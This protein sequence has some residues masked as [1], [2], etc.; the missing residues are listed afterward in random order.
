[1]KR[2]LRPALATEHIV[3]ADDARTDSVRRYAAPVLLLWVAILILALPSSPARASAVTVTIGAAAPA[4]AEG[5]EESLG[6]EAVVDDSVD[7]LA[8]IFD[9]PDYQRQLL[10]PGSGGQAFLLGLK[11]QSVR[12][13][14]L[15]AV[16][17]TAGEQALPDP[18]QGKDGGRLA[19]LA[20]EVTFDAG[21]ASWTI[22]PA[23]PMVG[24]ITLEALR[25]AKPDY[26]RL[27]GKYTP[28]AGA[29]K[30]IAAARE[31]KIV[32][33]FGNWCHLCKKAVPQLLKTVEAAKNPG[34]GLEFY[35]VTEDHLEPK[36]PIAKYSI[37]TTPVFVIIRGGKE[38]GRITEKPDV[39]V[40]KDLALILAAK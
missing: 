18:A 5:W 19:K 21:G 24:A 10:V 12:A 8:R 14:P 23:P 30:S 39:S 31:A 37:S 2:I 4:A 26:L 22:R 1:M 15:A 35:G 36:D 7:A 32:V 27:A 25:K 28:D 17:W 6:L 33:F 20:G 16:A 29:V 38:I 11:D 13:L 3:R 9:S 34:L 40:E